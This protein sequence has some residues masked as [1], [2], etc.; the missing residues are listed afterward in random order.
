MYKTA[1]GTDPSRG[2]AVT[3]VLATRTI[4]KMKALHFISEKNSFL[5]AEEKT[6]YFD[7]EYN[8]YLTIHQRN[9]SF[10]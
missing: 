2:L 7:T 10:T 5:N 4:W 3:L 8:E 1:A 9:A 6:T